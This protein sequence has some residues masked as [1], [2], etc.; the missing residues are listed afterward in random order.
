MSNFYLVQNIVINSET[1]YSLTKTDDNH[2]IYQ[3]RYDYE[4]T[5]SVNLPDITSSSNGY[6]ITLVNTDYLSITVNVADPP[7][8]DKISSWGM[9]GI[10]G[11]ASSNGNSTW[12]TTAATTFVLPPHMSISLIYLDN[13][14][15]SSLN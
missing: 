2:D 6:N 10:T 14:W 8:T 7:G 11:T 13:K 12:S 9:T 3:F 15:Y 5:P 1:S 4:I